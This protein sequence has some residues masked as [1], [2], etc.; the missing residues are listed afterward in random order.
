M[1]AARGRRAAFALA[2]GV[3]MAAP[4][5]VLAAAPTTL[6]RVVEAGAALDRGELDVAERILSRAREDAPRSALVAREHATVLLR[7]GR[8]EDALLAIDRALSLGD[9]DPEVLELRALILASL[10]RDQEARDT[11]ARAGTWEADLVGAALGDAS[12]AARASPWVDEASPRGALAALTLAAHAGS[13]GARTTARSLAA[14][15][16]DLARASDS[17]VVLDAARRLDA[18]LGGEGEGGERVRTGG[19]LR[20][21][22]DYATN[23]LFEPEGSRGK[24]QSLRSAVVAEAAFQAPIATARLDAAVRV[25]QRIQLVDRARLD[26]LDLSNLSLATSVEVPISSRPRAALLG[27]SFRF[28][29]LWGDAFDTHWATT[30][31]GGPTLTL[32]L[33]VSTRAILGVYGVGVD[34]I[35]R[36]PPDAQVSS[37]NRDRIGQRAVATLLHDA[38]WLVVRADAAF[39]RDDAYGEAF[40]LR[41]GLLGGRIDAAVTDEIVLRTGFSVLVRSFGPVGDAIVL[42]SAATRLEVRVMAELGAEVR[43]LEG[44]YLVVED[45][46]LTNSGR[47]GHDYTHNVLSLGLEARW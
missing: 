2:L 33:D 8:G 10:G 36:S 19:R 15:A 34:F 24:P 12:A 47:E 14:L 6:A 29:D 7:M 3:A 42:G 40:D 37:Q 45:A 30:F 25:D 41:G 18:R 16:Q 4:Q 31:E 35:D 44:Y 26:G 9:A 46:W 22:V 27:L 11:A 38:G 43:L 39:I 20:A 28:H 21:T 32:P 17:G 1:S 13:T 23:P 5:I